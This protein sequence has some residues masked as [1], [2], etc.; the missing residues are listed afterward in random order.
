MWRNLVTPTRIKEDPMSI[1][2]FLIPPLKSQCETRC[3]L[4]PFDFDQD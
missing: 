1:P 2:L 4:R 3:N